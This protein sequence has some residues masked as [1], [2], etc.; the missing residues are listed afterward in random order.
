VAG[1]LTKG[2][3]RFA[4]CSEYVFARRDGHFYYVAARYVAAW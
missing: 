1:A 2:F 4:Y 3:H